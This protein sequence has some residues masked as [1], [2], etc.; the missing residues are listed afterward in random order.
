MSAVMLEAADSPASDNPGRAWQPLVQ[1]RAFDLRLRFNLFPA[2]YAH[3]SWIARLGRDLPLAEGIDDS[4]FWMRRLSLA[5][6]QACKLDQD[7]DFDFSDRAKNIALLDAA[8]LERCAR[9]MAGLLVREQIRHVVLGADMVALERTLGRDSLRFALG[10]TVPL[11]VLGYVFHPH[12]AAFPDNE[13]W[14]RR[15]VGLASALLGAASSATLARMQ[16]R[17]PCG[18]ASLQRPVLQEQDRSRLAA[19]FVAVLHKAAPDHGW[20]FATPGRTAQ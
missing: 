8:V 15:A 1:D 10:W 4:P 17:F 6:L 14:T 5:L 3:A 18:W 9:L 16:L 13:A 7:F 11:P 19:L 12:G 2:T 20:L